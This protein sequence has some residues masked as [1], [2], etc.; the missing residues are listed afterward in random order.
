MKFLTQKFVNK[1][2]FLFQLMLVLF[3]FTLIPTQVQAAKT[4][5][6]FELSPSQCVAVR[7]GNTCYADV[8]I[9]WK[10][11]TNQNY[12]LYKAGD[13]TPIK[14]WNNVSQGQWVKEVQTKVDLEFLLKR[15]DSNQVIARTT[16]EVAWVYKK[17]LK[18][19]SS[20]RM[21]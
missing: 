19:T 9:Q 8:N 11:E 1:S 10:S 7:Q 6:A 13:K 18:R 15:K 21:F 14:C 17:S 16:L 3:S 2:I 12:C 20:W 5:I 4:P